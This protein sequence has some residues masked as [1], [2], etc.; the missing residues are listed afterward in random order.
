M[1]LGFMAKRPPDGGVKD[2]GMKTRTLPESKREV[3]YEGPDVVTMLHVLDRG[4][5]LPVAAATK[6]F[7][8][9]SAPDCDLIV[10]DPSLSK[11][12][13]LLERRGTALR[14]TDQGSY[15]GTY[16]GGRR[17]TTFDIR[18]GN[19]FSAAG[20]RFLALNEEMH[21]A[22]PQLV[23]IVAGE[24]DGDVRPG[25]FTAH[26]VIT[27]A[28]N[29]GHLLI[30]AEPGCDQGV[31]AKIIHA[32]SLRRARDLV[33]LGEVPADRVKQRAILDAASRSTIV[34][35]LDAKSPVMDGTFVS[36][37]FDRTYQIRV[38]VLAP[39]T[40]VASSV[41]GS[42]TLHTMQI[43]PLRPLA[44][45]PSAIPRLLDRLLAERRSSLR[46]SEMSSSNQAA[47]QTYDWPENM[48]ELRIGADK[49]KVIHEAASGRQ[50]ATKLGIH[51]STL[52][53][54]LDQIGLTLPLV[55]R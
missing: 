36:S 23:D 7:T 50:A 24:N 4:M 8:L 19:M 44:M 10:P 29:G 12:H 18:P 48:V 13:C 46:V 22:Y 3:Y 28:V 11:L 39:T 26:S 53:Y 45:R 32:I 54:W 35:S 40:S 2:G 37:L 51:H 47:L 21:R 6:R 30:T 1:V 31:L 14:V 52:Q 5:E 49:L 27:A 43:V 55:S 16:F 20:T 17:E 38:I 9:G 25:S 15:N 42:E 34:V 41:L 33:E